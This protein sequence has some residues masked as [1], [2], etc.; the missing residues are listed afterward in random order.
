SRI[1]LETDIE[2]AFGKRRQKG[3]RQSDCRAGGG[4]DRSRYGRENVGTVPHRPDKQ[5]F[6]EELELSQ[7][8][9][10][11]ILAEAYRK[12]I[13]RQPWRNGDRHE[14]TAQNRDHIGNSQ[15]GKKSTLDSR[16][17]EQ[18]QKDQDNYDCRI[19]HPGPDLLAGVGDY[20]QNRPRLT[21]FSIFIQAPQNVFEIDDSI[22]HEFADR[23]CQPAQGHRI[24]RQAESLK[25][26]ERH[27]DRER[28]RSQRNQRRPHVHQEKRQ[29]QR[30]NQCRFDQRLF[31]VADR[32][33]DECR[34]TKLD[35]GRRD[36]SRQG[37]LNTRERSLDV[38]G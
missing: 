10:V 18:R 13:I 17:R 30:D 1:V 11:S 22:V 33:L 5:Y 19:E 36:A 2:R 14:K 32:R 23:N 27:H 9:A 26:A 34:L 16:Q 37:I 8:K 24:D 20:F 4:D 29:N 28:D 38:L 12:E 35:V 6:V 7:K 25:N 21:A 31:Q 15:R 3:A